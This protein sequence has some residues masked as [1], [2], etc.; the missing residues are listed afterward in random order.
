MMNEQTRRPPTWLPKLHQLFF[1]LWAALFALLCGL[2][3]R[4]IHH[5]IL[6]LGLV[7][8]LMGLALLL[9]R[10]FR[11]RVNAADRQTTLAA[12]LL[13][14]FYFAALLVFGR[15]ML[16]TP[17]S[18]SG[19]V[20]FSAADVVE[21][22]SISRGVDE[23]T[24]CYWPTNTSN[25]DYFL[26]YPNSR[27]L[28]VYLLPLCRGIHDILGLDLRSDPAYFCCAVFNALHILAAVIFVFLTARKERGNAAALTALVLCLFFLPYYLN[29]FRTYSD[30]LSMPC[31]AAV[32]LVTVLADHEQRRGRR[33]LLRILAGLVLALGI[34]LKGNLWVLAVALAIDRLFRN[35]GWRE[36]A[37]E[38]A[39]LGLSLALVMSAWGFCSERLPWLDTAESDRY[40]LPT[41]NWILMASEKNGDFNEDVVEYLMQFE[42]L[43]ERRQ[44]ATDAYLQR[45]RD[46]GPAG[47]VRFT[48]R[49][50]SLTL[51]DGAYT[52]QFHLN[53]QKGKLLEPF[54]YWDAPYY[55]QF[56]FTV[57][58]FLYFMYLAIGLD[59]IRG[60]LD[61]KAGLSFLL[62]LSMF[63]LILFFC[64]WEVKSRYLLNYTPMFLLMTALSCDELARRPWRLKK[65]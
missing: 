63:G 36:A 62:H 10:R 1:A 31:T 25:H 16:V 59:A 56:R 35:R 65:R 9:L 8:V 50:I 54:L 51:Y 24:C 22:G 23:Y 3:L 2:S 14:G 64:F 40:E 61:R 30:T 12:V 45:L 47:F 5:R 7:L 26:V 37:L 27:F 34:L 20:W 21:T 19:T 58:V 17:W 38:L 29:V 53:E 55:W 32:L 28:V 33:L 60:M 48:L 42:T 52:Q 49:K 39:G 46:Y 13:L 18:D 44:A 15:I 6:C 4:Y 57:S 11:D 43:E 41:M